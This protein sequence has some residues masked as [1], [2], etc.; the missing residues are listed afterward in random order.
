MKVEGDFDRGDIV[1]IQG[2]DGKIIARGLTNYSA[3]DMSRIRGKKSQQIRELIAEAAYDEAVH[4]DNLV[5]DR[6]T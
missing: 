5:L 6:A 1:A 4:R 2:P 3:A